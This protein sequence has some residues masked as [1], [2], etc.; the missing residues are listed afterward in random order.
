MKPRFNSTQAWQQA[1]LL[2]QPALIRIVDNVRKRLDKSPWKATYEETQ[3]PVPGYTLRLELG[4]RTKT[5][6]VWELCYRVCF[7]EYIPTRTPDEPCDVE[8]DESLLDE[9]EVDW[10]RLDEKARQVTQVVFADLPQVD[11]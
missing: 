6:D 4:D 3:V 7:C 1:Q 5:V 11:C 8:I 10:D 2:M 9:G